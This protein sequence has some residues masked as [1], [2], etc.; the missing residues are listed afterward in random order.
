MKKIKMNKN[1]SKKITA[2]VSKEEAQYVA[3]LAKEAKLSVSNF[4]RVSIGLPKF[5][6]GLNFK[7]DNPRKH[8][9]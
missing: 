7:T 6:K 8:K 9:D 2:S 3:K 1:S 5:E 4:I